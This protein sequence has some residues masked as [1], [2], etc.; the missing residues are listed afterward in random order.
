MPSGVL[1]KPVGE[2]HFQFP[3]VVDV[4]WWVWLLPVSLPSPSPFDR[5]TLQETAPNHN[6]NMQTMFGQFLYTN[7]VY[8][9]PTGLYI[10]Y[11]IAILLMK[12]L[13]LAGLQTLI[14]I[15]KFLEEL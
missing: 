8:F 6:C 11:H 13:V 12:Q 1:E 4:P 3:E 10:V 5:S 9:C 15:T 14:T 2:I 7:I